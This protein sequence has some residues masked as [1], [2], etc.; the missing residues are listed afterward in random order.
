MQF[1]PLNYCEMLL[2]IW[3]KCA[4]I[5]TVDRITFRRRTCCSTE[6]TDALIRLLEVLREFNAFSEV[7]DSQLM[8]SD[9]VSE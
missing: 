4:S 3:Q 8:E 9:R 2:V 1:K 6:S 7:S 5:F